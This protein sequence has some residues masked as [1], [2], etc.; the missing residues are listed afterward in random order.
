MGSKHLFVTVGTTKF[1]KLISALSDEKILDILAKLGYT[2]IQFQTGNGHFKKVSHQLIDIKYNKYFEDF[3]NE[4]KQSDLVISH[5]GAGTC[6]EVLKTGKPLIVVINED[7]MDN[8]QIELAKHLS[9]K[10][11][12]YYCTCD[13]LKDIL[14]K[15]LNLLKAYP[16]ADANIFS[17][18]LDQCMGFQ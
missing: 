10:E 9:Q 16:L 12:L 2:S 18:Y 15:D 5:A 6:L 17:N 13:T 8:H 1:E 11:Y 3:Q 14:T 4:I 7:L